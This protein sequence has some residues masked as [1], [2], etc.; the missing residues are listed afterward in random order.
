[1][2]GSPSVASTMIFGFGSVS[3]TSAAVTASIDSP[4]GVSESGDAP[5]NVSSIAV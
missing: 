3:A 2:S 5:S 1:V 4:V